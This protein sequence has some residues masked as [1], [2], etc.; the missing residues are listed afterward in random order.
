MPKYLPASAKDNTLIDKQPFVRTDPN[1]VFGTTKKAVELNV[2]LRFDAAHDGA[3][4][5]V[6]GRQLGGLQSLSLLT[7]RKIVNG[8]VELALGNGVYVVDVP[9]DGLRSGFEVTGGAVTKLSPN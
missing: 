5:R 6:W 9:Q 4:A 2:V 3:D 1:I 8:Q 7:Q